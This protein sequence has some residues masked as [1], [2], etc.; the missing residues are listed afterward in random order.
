MK[1]PLKTG[2]EYDAI[3]TRHIYCY[4]GRAGVCKKAK[5]QINKRA[6]RLWKRRIDKDEGE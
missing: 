1:E 2:F 4:T 5:K 6:R 3:L